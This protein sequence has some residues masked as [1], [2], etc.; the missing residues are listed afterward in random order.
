MSQQAGTPHRII[1]KCG[2]FCALGFIWAWVYC[3]WKTELLFPGFTRSNIMSD[4]SWL[5]NVSLVIVALAATPSVAKRLGTRGRRALTAGATVAM[6][7]GVFASAGFAGSSG[8]SVV[9][10][11]LAGSLTGFGSG[12]LLSVCGAQL[13]RLSV[14]E[15]EWVVPLNVLITPLCSLFVP[16]LTGSIAGV[17]FVAALPL[18]AGLLLLASPDV[19]PRKAEPA[20]DRT[21]LPAPSRADLA[22]I[23]A[24]TA[25]FHTAGAA[26]IFTRSAE[27]LP[28]RFDTLAGFFQASMAFGTVATLA[29]CLLLMS[30]TR[31]LDFQSACRWSIPT[32]VA[33]AV[34]LPF[35]SFPAIATA[36]SFLVSFSSTY[37]SI[38]SYVIFV[39]FA[40]EGLLGPYAAIGYFMAA[41]E[42]GV[43]SGN[44][45]GVAS[46]H[47]PP[48]V[49]PLQAQVAIIVVA[50]SLAMLVVPARPVRGQMEAGGPERFAAPSQDEGT[51]RAAT[52]RAMRGLAERHGLTAREEEVCSLLASG[53]SR[54]YIRELLCVSKNTVDSHVKH[55]YAKLGVHSN[56]ELVDLLEAEE[57]F[58]AVAPPN[59]L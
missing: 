14:E 50:A 58:V 41:Y 28:S 11:Y 54:P 22:G 20:A 35:A 7:V 19:D 9:F 37:L 10:S 38:V 57:G 8:G 43:L 5:A 44:L 55:A 39:R 13:T 1:E 18:A 42:V 26:M 36:S 48:G 15:L 12:V 3:S 45:L 23:L 47:M 49:D 46:L 52:A 4:P 33:G 16:A 25:L 6:V 56:Q 17:T 24:C 40:K 32:Y 21:A 30:R 29:V 59:G 53:R 34:L 27:T 2:R 31:F 51:R